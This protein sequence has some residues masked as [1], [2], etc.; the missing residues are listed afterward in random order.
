VKKEGRT[1]PLQRL[2]KEVWKSDSIDSPTIKAT[3]SK[4]S[5]QLGDDPHAPR[6]ILSE[7]GVGYRFVRPV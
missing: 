5:K 3:V 1:V 4:L 6:M 2:A 7:H